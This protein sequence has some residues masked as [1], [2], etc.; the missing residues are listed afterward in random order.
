M[1]IVPC[2]QEKSTAGKTA[3]S[4][5][6]MTAQSAAGA[7]LRPLQLQQRILPPLSLEYRLSPGVGSFVFEA[8]YREVP[9]I[10][11]GWR[12]VCLVSEPKQFIIAQSPLWWA[13]T[14]DVVVDSNANI[15][16]VVVAECIVYNKCVDK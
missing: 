14:R 13:A 15:R 12:G 5:S 7:E 1:G 2:A 16:A 4:S 11:A 10:C 3:A 8:T 9:E 6:R